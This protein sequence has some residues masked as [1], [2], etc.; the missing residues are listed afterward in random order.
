ML[1]A[2]IRHARESG[3]SLAIIEGIRKPPRGYFQSLIETKQLAAPNPAADLRSFIGKRGAPQVARPGQG[4]LRSG[5]ESATRR[6]EE[7][8]VSP[9]APVHSHGP[10]GGASVGRVSGALPDGHRLASQQDP[11]GADVQREGDTYGHVQPDRHEAPAAGLERL[12]ERVGPRLVAM[13]QTHPNATRRNQSQDVRCNSA[14]RE[15]VEGKGFVAPRARKSRSFTSGPL[16]QAAR[17][18]MPRPPASTDRRNRDL[19]QNDDAC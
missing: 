10:A 9:V 15:V 3:R 18:S 5:G 7:G 12:L 1:G 17:E 8:I 6:N 14:R 4:V 16:H 19:L 11:R 2:V 13:R